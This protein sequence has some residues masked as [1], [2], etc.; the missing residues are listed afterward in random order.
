MPSIAGYRILET[1]T[2]GGSTRIYRA[3]R[4]RDGRTLVLKLP[5]SDSPDSAQIAQ[6]HHEYEILRSLPVAGVVHALDLERANHLPVLVL[7]E[8]PGRPLARVIAER[9][10]GLEQILRLAVQIASILE[11]VHRHGVIHKD[12]NPNNL[13]V[14]EGLTNVRLSD[15]GIATRLPQDAR[16]D[17]GVPVCQGTLDFIAPEQ[18]GRMNRQV[19]HRADLYSLGVTLYRLLTGKLPFVATDPLELVH[20][21]IAERPV[22]PHQLRP[23]VPLGLSGLV[24]KLLAKAPEDRYQSAF[25]LKHD[26]RQCLAWLQTRGAIPPF[27]LGRRDVPDHFWPTQQLYGREQEIAQ[28]MLAVE[29]VKNGETLLFLVTGATGVGKSALVDEVRLPI[30]REWGYFVSGKFDR[31][32]RDIPYRG[33]IL[34]LQQL[35][36]QL[37]SEEES[38]IGYWRERI[39]EAVGQSG[40]VLTDIIPGLELI[41]GPQPEVE[42]LP[43]AQSRNRFHQLF[44]RLI[45][46]F[47]REEHPLVLFLDDLQ[48]SDSASVAILELLLLDRQTPH[49]LLIGAYRKREGNAAAAQHV[50]V[51]GLTHASTAVEQLTLAPLTVEAVQ[52]LVRDIFHCSDEAAAALTAAVYQK[53]RGNPFFV[54]EFLQSLYDRKLIGFVPDAG[55]WHWDVEE[56]LALEVTD[57][58]ADFMVE[59]I[60]TLPPKTRDALQLAACIGSRFELQTF[61]IAADCTTNAAAELLW[62]ALRERLI[63]PLGGGHEL[64]GVDLESHPVAQDPQQPP[65]SRPVSYR[66]VHDRVQQA[67]Y[68]LLSAEQ[69]DAFHYRIGNELLSRLREGER[70][71]QLPHIVNQLNKGRG[72]IDDPAQ[73]ERVAALNLE[74]GRKAKAAAAFVPALHFFSMG[75]R[76]LPEGS[77]QEL[78]QLTLELHREQAEC[79]YLTGALTEAER[80]FDALLIRDLP[81]LVKAEIYH[82]RLLLY[83]A[84]GKYDQAVAQGVAGLDLLGVRIDPSASVPSLLWEHLL[85]RLGLR[86]RPGGPAKLA[87]LPRM[88][89]PQQVQIQRLL[90]SLGTPTY[91]SGRDNLMALTNLKAVR[92]SLNHGNADAS[93]YA[94]SGYGMLLASVFR[95][96]GLG[97]EFARLAQRLCEHS[98]ALW[99]RSKTRFIV[100]IGTLHW[101]RPLREGLP[102]AHQAYRDSLDSGDNLFG[103]YL[104][105]RIPALCFL[106]GDTLAQVTEQAQEYLKFIRGTGDENIIDNARQLLHIY[107]SLQ[108]LER[109]AQAGDEAP[110]D[111][112]AALQRMLAGGY[113]SGVAIYHI[114]KAQAHLLQ[115]DFLAAVRMAEQAA[116]HL[117]SLIGLPD[118][119]EVVFY[120]ALALASRIHQSVGFE[121]L[122]YRAALRPLLARLRRWSRHCPDNFAARCN[123]VQAEAA[124]AAGHTP[125]AMQLFEQAIESAQEQ[126]QTQIEAMANEW[127][128]HFHQRSGRRVIALGYLRAAL[129]A[130]RRWGAAPKAEAVAQTLMEWEPTERRPNQIGQGTGFT[131]AT[132]NQNLDLG[133]VVKAAETISGE[134]L[135]ENLLRKLINLVVE[136]AG[137][138]RGVLLL[139]SDDGLLVQAE[140]LAE[141]DHCE[142]LQALPLERYPR[143]PRSVVN[144]VARSKL[145]VVL[146]DAAHAEGFA[147]DPY[148]VERRPRSVLCL[149]I[150]RQIKLIGVLYLENNLARGAF[151]AERVGLLS[152]LSSQMAISIENADLY[153]NLQQAAQELEEYNRELESKVQERTEELHRKN[154]ALNG[155]LERVERANS[156]IMD[157]L[158]YAKMIQESLLPSPER[159][160]GLFPN[161]FVLWLPRDIVGGDVYFM[162]EVRGSR[163]LVLADC[164][165][166]GVPGALLTVIAASALRQIVGIEG[167]T[168]PAEILRRLNVMVKTALHQDTDQAAS[169]DGLD[170]A[171]CHIDAAGRELSFSGAALPLYYVADGKL[172]TIRGDRHS[173]GYKRSDL[174]HRFATHRLDLEQVSGIYL[175]SDGYMDQLGGEHGFPMGNSRF[176]RLLLEQQQRP[177]EQQREQLRAALERYRGQYQR[178]DDVTLLGFRT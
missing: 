29:R 106:K 14:D 80:S 93:A 92:L 131:I 4:D 27:E 108:G 73:Q 68:S 159:L 151:T 98:D 115:R 22:P 71:E 43:A 170:A 32:Q 145:Q 164:T 134:M 8:L 59:R 119:A 31:L 83:T 175:A 16:A 171:V 169:D 158:L 66:F 75:V 53:T 163:I 33:F 125:R 58:V 122:Q 143:L 21:H 102:P 13:I 167:C 78:P 56:I 111:E 24:V 82:V 65:P 90:V 79:Q 99:F 64:A 121:R 7:E 100:A 70:A 162:E 110:F 54:N 10:L 37:L 132:D 112:Q 113:R 41:I 42:T 126:E 160:S 133:T 137:A 136:N 76:L 161:S 141:S 30:A 85:I 165:G 153:R 147:A 67:A 123:L 77:W 105:I 138:Q 149:P 74:A 139:A 3:R 120:H 25:G 20:K 144:Y 19:D 69:R 44:L 172:Q 55:Q 176:Q 135:S 49:L 118:T 81:P 5:H 6:L 23:T 63:Q 17:G 91:L 46:V 127:A 40:R 155:A 174:E 86:L 104:G 150:L 95:S 157:S 173:I 45:R 50:A 166:H 109:T 178:Q 28:L 168:E 128:A 34:A 94:Y 36:Q 148:I 101:K 84:I 48:W 39:L 116:P 130:Y 62:P 18:T 51:E 124:A 140:R 154:D 72:H 89:D 60:H 97:Y 88:E 107:L 47:A 15:F 114:Y 103:C 1:L 26:L 129:T 61:A 38:R 35:M 96:I 12:V 9:E 2:E 156:Q 52:E 146:S 117:H 177:A 11:K 152:M 142:L 87:E 57:N